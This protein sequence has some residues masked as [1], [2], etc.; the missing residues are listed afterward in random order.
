MTKIELMVLI[1]LRTKGASSPA[2]AMSLAELN[3]TEGLIDYKVNSIYK[4]IR[5]LCIS[6]YVEHG[7]KDGRADTYYVTNYGISK[8]GEYEV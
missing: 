4:C 8:I 2:T 3:A 1:M 5:R 7:L 6:S